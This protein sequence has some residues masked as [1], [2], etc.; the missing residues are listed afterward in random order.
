MQVMGWSQLGMLKRYE[1][2]MDSV[3]TDAGE[4]LEMFWKANISL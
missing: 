1:H 4:R 3:L 2:V